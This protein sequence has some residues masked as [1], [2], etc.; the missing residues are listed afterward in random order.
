MRAQSVDKLRSWATRSGSTTTAADRVVWSVKVASRKMPGVTCLCR[1]LALQR[2]LGKYGHDSELM[3]GVEKHNDR[4]GA[5]AWLV[6]NDQ[7][8]IGDSQLG[9]YELLAAWQSKNIG[10]CEN[11][12]E[13]EARL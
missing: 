7:I 12:H 2:L 11:G 8:L 3:I 6:H 5:H 13:D 10:L 1:A 9:K 4:F